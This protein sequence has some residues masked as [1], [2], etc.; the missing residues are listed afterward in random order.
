MG[1]SSDLIL[2]CRTSVI[3][4]IE[5]RGRIQSKPFS[6]EY[7]KGHLIASPAITRLQ[8]KVARASVAQGHER[9]TPVPRWLSDRGPPAFRGDG[10]SLS[11]VKYLARAP[12]FPAGPSLPETKGQRDGRI[13]GLLGE[14]QV[15][16]VVRTPIQ[17][18]QV[19]RGVDGVL[20]GE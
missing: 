11:L 16:G 6:A 10:K 1:G 3:L 17:S 19:D 8:E 14:T 9:G 7:P 12:F 20:G 18:L 15:D 2:T 5:I 13:T 4:F